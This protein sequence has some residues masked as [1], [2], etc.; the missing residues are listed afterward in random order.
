MTT[1]IS[2][3]G[4]RSCSPKPPPSPEEVAAGR[5][6]FYGQ[7]VHG[8]T[9]ARHHWVWIQAVMDE[10]VR[11]LLIISPPGHAKS[12]WISQVYPGW[13]IGRHPE[14]S[15]LLVS[16]TASQAELFLGVVRDTLRQN[17]RYW[18]VF[19][20]IRPDE[21]RG[22]THQELFVKRENL[23]TKDATLFATGV[24][25]PLIGRRAQLIIVDDP[26]DEDNSATENQ[27]NKVKT[28]YKRTLLS[29]LM[30]DGRVIVILT[31]WHEDDLA[32]DLIASGE[33][34][35]MHMKAI[36]D[37]GRALWPAMWP[38]EKLREKKAEL[39]TAL[40]QCMY[41]GDPTALGGNIFKREWFRDYTTV[42]SGLTV[43]QAWDLAISQKQSAD[44]TAGVTI[45]IDKAQNVYVLDVVRGRWSFHEQ[46]L[47]MKELAEQWQ[48]AAV[49]IET[50][51]YQAAAF[52]E[53]VR[54]SLWAFEE[55]KPERDKVSRARFPAAR[56]E[57]GTVYVRKRATWWDEL[58]SEIMAFP[59]GKH[60]D[61]VDALVYAMLVARQKQAKR[62]LP[63]RAMVG[64]RRTGASGKA[65][66]VAR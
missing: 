34:H 32:A 22:W 21:Q 35:V 10:R 1:R 64:A 24:G 15:A 49:G 66:G 52:Q 36:S 14:Q 2:Q 17:E 40:F 43:F 51:A 37:G 38:L 54:G 58:E 25:G 16:N 18:Q 8:L 23:T 29:R 57:A 28:W 45:G 48:P 19:P 47:R 3:S 7:Y 42:P 63:S 41:Q 50:V 56:A 6:G 4:S 53:A 46:Q 11:K 20:G 60:D 9:P 12:T 39:G 33:Y 44:Y 31:R 62:P 65:P 13:W 30:P 5:L 27:R 26:L 61:Q 55:V 59:N